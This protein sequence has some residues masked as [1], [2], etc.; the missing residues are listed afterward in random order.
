LAAV[1]ASISLLYDPEATAA[2]PKRV[3]GLIAAVLGLGYL[4]YARRFSPARPAWWCWLGFLSWSALSTLWGSEASLVKLGTWVGAA[5]VGAMLAGLGASTTRR[6]AE[7]GALMVGAVSSSW[8]LLGFIAGRRG[9]A[10]HAGQGNPNWLGLLLAT[11][12]PLVIGIAVSSENARR[13]RSLA[14]FTALGMTPAL[15]LS[16][17][18]VGWVAAAVGLLVLGLATRERPTSGRVLLLVALFVG[19]ILAKNFASRAPAPARVAAMQQTT[20]AARPDRGDP[21]PTSSLLDRVWIQRN[22]WESALAHLPFGAGLGRFAPA[23]FQAQGRALASLELRAAARR[24]SPAT[25][26]HNDWL[27]AAVESGPLGLGLLLVAVSLA[28]RDHWRSKWP[29]G[30][31]ALASFSVTALGD[32][33]LEQ[34]APAIFLALVLAASEGQQP[35]GVGSRSVGAVW[36][37][38]L[39][40]AGSGLLLPRSI[41]SWLGARCRTE[42]RRAPVEQRWVLLEK[43]VR[44]DSG[45]GANALELGLARLELG[46]SASGLVE[47]ERAAW[48]LGDVGSWVAA[49]NAEL[50]RAEPTRAERAFQEALRLNPGSFRAHLNLSETLR[51]MEEFAGAEKHAKIATLLLPGDA[52]ARELLDRIREEAMDSSLRVQGGSSDPD[53]SC[54]DPGP[55]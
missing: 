27:E 5:G 39:L 54:A 20:P 9:L 55:Q 30:A 26:A 17:S 40:L 10:L 44:L 19:T 14:W 36:A 18:R 49:G 41:G 38:A 16:A 6:V 35:H 22:A 53:L 32:S 47:L 51:R 43:S 24:F 45:S 13:T 48:L 21:S 29:A 2:D 8:V 46:D 37:T 52:R 12:W 33:P 23:F 3:L 50:A 11:I 34:P 7:L 25:T 31:A 15:V 4:L 1:V 42:A 28:F